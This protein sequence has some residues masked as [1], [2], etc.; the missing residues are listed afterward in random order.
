MPLFQYLHGGMVGRPAQH[1]GHLGGG[2]VRFSRHEGGGVGAVEP[3]AVVEEHH[4]FGLAF[5]V[6]VG[7]DF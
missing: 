6:E 7:D 4:L 5:G 2:E 1:D 3:R